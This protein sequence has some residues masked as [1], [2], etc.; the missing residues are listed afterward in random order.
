MILI[1]TCIWIDHFIHPDP[2]VASLVEST[3]IVTHP[4][5]IGELALGNLRNRTATLRDLGQ[6]VMLMPVRHSQV[7]TFVE[8]QK[9]FGTGLHYI[10]VHLLASVLV[11]RDC[12][13]WTRDKRLK[14]VAKRLNVVADYA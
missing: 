3:E 5:I 6:L 4:M 13:L 8:D 9:L 1:D 10:D 2:M 7:L 11:T 14:A 12:Q